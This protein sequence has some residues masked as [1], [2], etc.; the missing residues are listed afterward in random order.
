MAATAERR[1]RCQDTARLLRNAPNRSLAQAADEK[2][3]ARAARKTLLAAA[4]R[5]GRCAA[6]DAAAAADSN[7]P[8]NQR[9]AAAS[10]RVMPPSALR[11]LGSA[12]VAAK[13]SGPAAWPARTDRFARAAE[14]SGKLASGVDTDNDAVLVGVAAHQ[15]CPPDALRRPASRDVRWNVLATVAANAATP[16]ATLDELA[17]HMREQVRM[18]VAYNRSSSPDTLERLSKDP[19]GDIRGAAASNPLRPRTAK[20]RLIR[21]A[22]RGCEKPLAAIRSRLGGEVPQ[23]PTAAAA[24]AK[25]GSSGCGSFADF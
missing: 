2:L 6:A 8:L 17:N 22:T 15:A 14:P 25:A 9:E 4:A 12:R 1:N 21:V 10:H 7:R 5:R 23:Q 19:D 16:A 20:R 11:V 24:T 13:G 18:A 3:G